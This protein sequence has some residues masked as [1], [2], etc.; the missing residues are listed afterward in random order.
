MSTH[1][2]PLDAPAPPAPSARAVVEQYLDEQRAALLA[3]G[4]TPDYC[5]SFTRGLRQVI[6]RRGL[7]WAARAVEAQT[8]PGAAGTFSTDR[9]GPRALAPESR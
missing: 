9:A 1:R 8:P 4:R 6:A 5:E 2:T 3:A 7:Q